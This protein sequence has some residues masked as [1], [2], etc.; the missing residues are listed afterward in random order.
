MNK[1][2]VVMSRWTENIK[3]FE[4]VTAPHDIY[5]YNR[6]SDKMDLGGYDS[7]GR[8]NVQI[9]DLED[10]NGYECSTNAYHCYSRYNSLND[11]VVFL[12]GKSND[13]NHCSNIV[14]RLNNPEKLIH[15]KY[16]P[17]GIP[18]L[19]APNVEMGGECI[20]FEYMADRFGW[21]DPKIDYG[22]T[23]YADDYSKI[24]WLEFCKNMPGWSS[25]YKSPPTP[26]AFGMASAFIVS[27]KLILKHE[28]DYYRR[29]QQFCN[30]YK[31]PNIG[32]PK[33]YD[34]HLVYYGSSL[35]EGIWKY[36]F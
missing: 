29:I 3:W 15:T 21:L 31:D 36:V 33:R 4:N 8:S 25:D 10:D 27:K 18:A 7:K 24:P 30:T 26:Q 14:T 19:V 17:L 9:I 12:Q 23:P 28:P 5:I 6:N 34:G 1:I 22:W 11:F 2:G 13:V 32:T 20:E 35:M 16:I